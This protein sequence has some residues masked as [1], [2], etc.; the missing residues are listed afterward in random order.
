MGKNIKLY[1]SEEEGSYRFVMYKNKKPCS[2]LQVMSR[3]KNTG[4][5]ANVITIKEERRKGYAKKLYNTALRLIPTI[6]HSTN[7]SE[8][9]KALSTDG[10]GE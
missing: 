9:G 3:D 4:I 6:V 2:A 10:R 1:V 5:V 7:L 8:E